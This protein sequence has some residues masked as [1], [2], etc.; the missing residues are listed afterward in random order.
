MDGIEGFWR[1]VVGH[2]DEHSWSIVTMHCRYIFE[3]T[4]VFS[5]LLF[6]VRPLL[7]T[8]GLVSAYRSLEA[9]SLTGN[10]MLLS[11]NVQ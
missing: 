11:I 5:S 10:R 8:G 7:T 1:G 9:S 2:R 4:S 6:T 3:R